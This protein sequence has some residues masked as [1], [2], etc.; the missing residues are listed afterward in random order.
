MSCRKLAA[1]ASAALLAAPPA[2]AQVSISQ[3][4]AASALSGVEVAPVVQSGATVKATM[5]QISTYVKSTGVPSITGSPANNNLAVFAG[6]STLTNGD[7]SGDCTTSGTLAVVCTKTNGVA[8]GSAANKNTGTSGSTVPVLN[9]ANTW[10]ATQTFSGSS[11]TPGAIFPNIAETA[12][13]S[14][15]AAT[16]TV[17]YDVLTQS[18]LYYTTNASGNWTLNIRGNGSTSLGSMLSTGQSVTIAFLVTQ[19]S[20]AF[21]NATVQVDGTT[22][23]VT[24]KWQNG[25]APAAGDVSA[26]DIYTYTVVKTGSGAYTVFATMTKFA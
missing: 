16:G 8:F 15:T 3:L 20:P 4:P 25:S 11:T 17:N 14:A 22:S 2:W 1:L 19:G 5:T 7:L 12:T 6:A 18:V 26:V 10:G 21:F 23:G 9:A 13:V 24:T